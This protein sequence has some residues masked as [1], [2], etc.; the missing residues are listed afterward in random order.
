MYD[1]NVTKLVFDDYESLAE[2][3]CET[4]VEEKKTIYT[5]LLYDD[6]KKLLNELA[7]FEDSEL[8]NIEIHEP[9][10]QGYER[11]FYIVVDEELHINVEVAYHEKNEYHDACYYRFGDEEVIA[12]LGSDTNCKLLD[13][14]DGACRIYEIEIIDSFN[15]DDDKYL[16]C[17]CDK[18]DAK[19]KD[20]ENVDE[21]KGSDNNSI[22][23]IAK[24]FMYFFE[25]LL[26][27]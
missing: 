12:L 14:V 6:A 22:I 26:E 8:D 21:S 9:F 13:A 25:Y 1:K 5:A 23:D 11:E 20:K 18:C 4:A 3:I 19:Q 17:F 16:N 10:W 24:A 15:E 2:Y 27:E 7:L